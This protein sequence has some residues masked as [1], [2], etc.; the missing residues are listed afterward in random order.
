MI[1]FVCA[2]NYWQVSISDCP[3]FMR[4]LVL[5]FL[6]L[7]RVAVASGGG[8]GQA[9]AVVTVQQYVVAVGSAATSSTYHTCMHGLEQQFILCFHLCFRTRYECKG[10]TRAG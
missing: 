5:G 4:V 6:F 9:A 3:L 7:F 10:N 2:P 1:G 8:G